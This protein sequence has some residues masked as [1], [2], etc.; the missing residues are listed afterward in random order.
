MHSDSFAWTYSN[1]NVKL[2]EKRETSKKVL[3]VQREPTAATEAPSS[4]ALSLPCEFWE[5]IFGDALPKSSWA[6][7]NSPLSSAVALYRLSGSFS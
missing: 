4:T 6:R 5:G 1:I 7:R 2:Q 3:A